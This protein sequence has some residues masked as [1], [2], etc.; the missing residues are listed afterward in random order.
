MPHGVDMLMTATPDLGDESGSRGTSVSP[1]GESIQ[2]IRSMAAFGTPVS[3]T[4]LP[5][6]A[7]PARAHLGIGI[8]LLAAALLLLWL[9]RHAPRLSRKR[10]A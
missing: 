9:A 10:W 3:P 1:R 7:T 4:R 8:V 5:A 6:T 2:A